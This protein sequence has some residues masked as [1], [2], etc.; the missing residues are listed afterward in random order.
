MEEVFK[1][2]VFNLLD[3]IIKKDVIVVIFLLHHYLAN[4]VELL[5]CVVLQQVTIPVLVLE[6]PL[7]DARVKNVVQ[8]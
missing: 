3:V 7:V 5:N 8:I 1:V 6:M 2:I 4:Y